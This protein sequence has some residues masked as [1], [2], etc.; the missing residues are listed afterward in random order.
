MDNIMSFDEAVTRV[1]IEA[2]TSVAVEEITHR[3]SGLDTFNWP[4]NQPLSDSVVNKRL[5]D[6]SNIFNVL[7]RKYQ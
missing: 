5:K 7:D 2:K 3:L 6:K 1:L 4:G